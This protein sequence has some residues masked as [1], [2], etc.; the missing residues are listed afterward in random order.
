MTFVKDLL[1][2]T[3]PREII[4][5]SQDLEDSVEN[6]FDDVDDIT[7]SLSGDV[8]TLN[9]FMENVIESGSNTNGSWVKFIDGTMI[10]YMSV[11]DISVDTP[12]GAIFQSDVISAT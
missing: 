8:N 4:E 3:T 12:V 10:A 2:A 7:T 9:D 5:Y 11:E 6:G 1:N